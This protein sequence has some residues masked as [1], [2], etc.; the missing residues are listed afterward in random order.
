MFEEFG[1]LLIQVLLNADD[2]NRRHRRSQTKEAEP[3]VAFPYIFVQVFL[4]GVSP[5]D[6]ER[7]L[8]RPIEQELRDAVSV[9]AKRGKVDVSIAVARTEDTTVGAEVNVAR[10]KQII[11]HLKTLSGLID[12]SAP[13]SATSLMRMPGVIVEEETDPER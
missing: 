8:V 6:A 7:L 10:A 1:S 11:A 12:N 2:A 3:D 5:E 9:R 4:E 13:I